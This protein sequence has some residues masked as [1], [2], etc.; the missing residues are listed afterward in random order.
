MK[1]QITIEVESVPEKT[2]FLSQHFGDGTMGDT[3]FDASF[4]LPAMS[5]VVKIDKKRYKV[6]MPH[7]I[8]KIIQEIHQKS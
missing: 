7:I 5:L 3:K 6:A 8:E 4:A 1:K 2:M